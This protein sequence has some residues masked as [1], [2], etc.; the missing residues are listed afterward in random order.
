[1]VKKSFKIAEKKEIF[2]RKENRHQ[3]IVFPL[4]VF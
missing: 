3:E 4:H 1:M 2:N